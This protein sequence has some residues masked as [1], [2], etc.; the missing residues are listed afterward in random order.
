[1][2][3]LH[4]RI[5]VLW[6]EDKGLHV[7]LIIL[8][9]QIFILFPFIHQR[10][11]FKGILVLFYGALLYLGLL[12]Y[13]RAGRRGMTWTIGAVTFAM[14]ILFGFATPRW[15]T[16][17]N[18]VLF[19][20]YC[21]ALAYIVLIRTLSPG[22]INLYRIEGSIVTFLLIGLVFCFLHDMI[23]LIDGPAAYKGLG[24]GDKKEF[25]YFSLTTLTTVG[26]GD[27]TPAIP[28]SRSAA[29]LEALIG[30]LYP[31]ILIARLV[32]KDTLERR[33]Q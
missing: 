3:S 2:L 9:A 14:A 23:F 22:P 28:A 4:R 19:I 1:M 32:S 12:Q 16:I 8:I 30:Q 17:A 13:T 7:L 5:K 15:T 6:I 31:A 26:Y 10:A 18:D 33:G 21:I 27:I 11:L 20:L 29:N 25:M 24:A